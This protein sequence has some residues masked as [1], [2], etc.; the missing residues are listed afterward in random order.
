MLTATKGGKGNFLAISK[1]GVNKDQK[2]AAIITPAEKPK[3]TEKN[4]GFGRFNKKT[5]KLP[6]PVAN[7]VNI[8]AKST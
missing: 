1:A 6:M 5:P 7:Q 3:D 4:L 8:P 2:L